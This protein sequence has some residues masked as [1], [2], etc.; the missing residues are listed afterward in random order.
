MNIFTERLPEPGTAIMQNMTMTTETLV[1]LAYSLEAYNAKLSRNCRLRLQV[2][3]RG[4]DDT[5]TYE[6][7]LSD[8]LDLPISVVDT[9]FGCRSSFKSMREAVDF[10]D[11]V[12]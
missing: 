4:E 6:I 5:A 11:S 7:Q 3:V 12:S 8:D 1:Q 10:F 9:A 2:D